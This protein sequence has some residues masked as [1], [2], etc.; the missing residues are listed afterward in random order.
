MWNWINSIFKKPEKRGETKMAEAEKP[1]DYLDMAEMI[2]RLKLHEGCSLK[3]YKCPAGKLT[4]GI[5]RNTEDNPFTADELKAVGDW[6]HG[7]TREAAHMLCRNDIER[8][9]KELKKNLKWF[10][11]L[12]KERKYALI[13]LC[14]NLGVRSLMM[15]KKTLASIGY[16]NYKTAAEQLLQSKY[17]KQVG[18]RALRIA[19]LIETG[20][21]EICL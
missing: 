10:E 18:K 12:D 16:G 2:T 9:I 13:D 8:C 3:P 6:K 1:I 20:R 21:W 11:K 15:F 5:G 19:K 4:I 7:I 17:A 14:F